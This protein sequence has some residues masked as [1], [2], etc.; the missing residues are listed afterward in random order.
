M[1]SFDRK[2]GTPFRGWRA[3]FLGALLSAAMLAGC[4]VQP[5]YGPKMGGGAVSSALKA[6]S[7]DPA[8]GRTAQIVRNRL[9]SD[10]GAGDA[11]PIYNLH[12]NVT[13]SESALGIGLA[14]A[15]PTNSVTVAV[16]YRL[17]RVGTNDIILRDSERASASYE[18]VNQAYT[19][20][21]AQLDAEERAAETAAEQVR[22]RIASALAA[23]S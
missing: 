2:G 1:S 6:I 5:V 15:S 23:R 16:S 21:R 10:F 7:I 22:L 4:T 19:N 13:V 8:D 14:G 12:L 11:N 3:G 20:V 17:T 18:R 9:I